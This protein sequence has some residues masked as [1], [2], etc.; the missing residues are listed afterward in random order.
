MADDLTP[1]AVD[2]LQDVTVHY[3]PWEPVGNPMEIDKEPH[4]TRFLFQNPDGFGL[5]H[6]LEQILEH[7]LAM[8][9]DHLVLPETKTNTDLNWVKA[10]VYDHCRRIVGLGTY[11]AVMASTPL[12]YHTA[13][14]P[15]GVLAVTMGKL[16]GR[17]LETGSDEFGRWV[18]T[19]F[20]ASGN[21]NVTVIGIYQP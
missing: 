11:R 18:H 4:L 19:K 14:K 21:K 16:S 12:E 5:G 9:C 8:Q 13:Y 15:G 10:K 20:N 17:V 7:G 2:E 3:K 6:E 1:I